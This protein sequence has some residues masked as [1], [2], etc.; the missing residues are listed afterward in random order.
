[1]QILANIIHLFLK[2]NLLALTYPINENFQIPLCEYGSI[3]NKN[4]LWVIFFILT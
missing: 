3:A 4:S 2:V 1:M